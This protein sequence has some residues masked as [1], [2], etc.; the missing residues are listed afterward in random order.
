MSFARNSLLTAAPLVLLLAACGSADEPATDTP[1]SAPSAG[2]DTS[3]VAGEID[4]TPPIE[5]PVEVAVM[6]EITD[7]PEGSGPG[8]H[9][10]GLGELSA[11]LEGET[12]TI[13]FRSPMYNIVGFERAPSNDE[14]QAALDAAQETL[15]SGKG[16]FVTDAGAGC[17]LVEVGVTY[18]RTH[19]HGDDDHDHDH[20]DDEHEHSEDGDDHSEDEH[21]HAEDDANGLG[22][23]EAD[24]AFTCA[25]PEELQA[26]D[27]TLFERFGRFEKING[28]ALG[29]GTETATLTPAKTRLDMPD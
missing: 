17:Q 4:T 22:E 21:D 24:Y 9:V 28:I 18:F 23:V 26:V 10:H 13:T 2:Q 14:E 16:L 12:L 1:G 29:D 20:S 19:K 6:E 27:V 5:A 8:A 11:V 25:A 3:M 15:R 7:A